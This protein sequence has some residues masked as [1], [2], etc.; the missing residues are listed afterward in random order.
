MVAPNARGQEAPQKERVNVTVTFACGN[1]PDSALRMRY[2]EARNALAIHLT[3][4]KDIVGLYEF[5][6]V[7]APGISDLDFLI[8]AADEPG[9][10]LAAVLK[11]DQLPPLVLRFMNGGTLMVMRAAEFREMRWWDDVSVRHLSGKLISF[12]NPDG[13]ALHAVEVARVIDWL[14][15]RVSRLIAIAQRDVIPVQQ[16]LCLLHSISYTF[17]RLIATFAIEP[18]HITSCLCEIAALRVGWFELDEM[19]RQLRL[20][21]IVAHTLS[22]AMHALCDFGQLCAQ[23]NLYAEPDNVERHLAFGRRNRFA[24]MPANKVNIETALS[25][26]SAE[27][28]VVP[29]PAVLWGH[30]AAYTVGG[31]SVARS[32]VSCMSPNSLGGV[33]DPTMAF[34]L[35]R[36]MEI[37][38]RMAA[39]LRANGFTSGLWKMGWFL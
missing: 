34:V 35:A 3:A 7:S 25:L 2:D 13:D 8:V 16:T 9:S 37:V 38:E 33:V 39:W 12:D 15:E 30:F 4:R 29:V 36:R 20:S 14:P 26:S 11:A 22:L 10:D 31:G 32:L 1:M 19:E 23:K 27:A 5:G 18:P 28:A 21:A 6:T 17:R 24:F